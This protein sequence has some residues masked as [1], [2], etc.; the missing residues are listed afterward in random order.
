MH[1][2]PILR[3]GAYVANHYLDKD[4]FVC[5][6]SGRNRGSPPTTDTCS[7]TILL[8]QTQHALHQFVAALVTQLPQVQAIAEVSI[9]VA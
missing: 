7:G 2:F 5:N 1:G 4:S 9:F 3:H 8:Y 6:S